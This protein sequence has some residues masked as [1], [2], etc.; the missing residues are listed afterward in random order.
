MSDLPAYMTLQEVAD[1]WRINKR[2]ASRIIRKE[3]RTAI[4]RPTTNTM[5]IDSRA[6]LDLERERRR[7][8]KLDLAA[9]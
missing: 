2:T 1:R 5:L 8:G 9:A 6:V 7:C 3:R 4:F